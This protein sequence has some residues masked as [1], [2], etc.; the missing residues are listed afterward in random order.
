MQLQC[1]KELGADVAY[2]PWEKLTLSEDG[3][4]RRTLLS[5]DRSKAIRRS[6]YLSTFGALPPLISFVAKLF[7]G[8]TAGALTLPVIQDARFAFDWTRPRWR[9]VCALSGP[10]GLV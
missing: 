2:G 6:N 5:I 3:N 7:G 1:L 4:Y 8:P 10:Y 9:T